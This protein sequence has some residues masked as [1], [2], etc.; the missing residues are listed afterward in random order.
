LTDT[1]NPAQYDKFQRERGQ[2][3][4]D[5]LSMIRPRH[6]MR[7]ADLGCGTGKLTRL[8]HTTLEARDTIGID[9]SPR[10]L[11]ATEQDDL[12]PG[13]RFEVGTIE[14]FPGDR[15]MFDLIFSNAAYHWVDD[16]RSL[17]MRLRAALAPGGQ[18]AFQVPAQHHSP[19]HVTAEEL[20]REAPFRSAFGGWHRPQPVLEPAAYASLLYQLGFAK[21]SVRLIVYP[22]VLAG[23]AEVVEWMKGTLLT[24]YARHL[25]PD[26][27]DRFVTEY[28]ARLLPQLEDTRPFFFPFRRIL[29]WAQ[30]NGAAQD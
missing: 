6:G 26:L 12:P 22:H 7:V 14:S 25:P 27:Y 23:P 28:Q 1:W 4:F 13:L 5:L 11:D 20:T 17:L 8:L 16:H 18:I 19:S 24:E 29:C 21:P 10:M 15:G 30:K 9:R 3:F 2:P